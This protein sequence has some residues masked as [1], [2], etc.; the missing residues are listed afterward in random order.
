[1]PVKG[2]RLG[3]VALE[4]VHEHNPHHT[5]EQ[6]YSDFT[7][8]PTAKYLT[9]SPDT[10]RPPTAS[11]KVVA[12][13]PFAV[14]PTP[15]PQLLMLPAR[16]MAIDPALRPRVSTQQTD[17]YAWETDR[18]LAMPTTGQRATKREGKLSGQRL[19][20]Y[21]GRGLKSL[22]ILAFFIGGAIVDHLL[23]AQNTTYEMV[24]L[25]LLLIAVSNLYSGML[26]GHY[27][28][29]LQKLRTNPQLDALKIG[30]TSQF[31]VLKAETT[32]Y[33]RAINLTFSR[34]EG[35]HE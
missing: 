25:F 20:G 23:L 31:G 7:A 9:M 30:V 5:E 21:T 32:A 17:A 16:T 28:A 11:Q 24:V 27:N 12:I 4:R 19:R 26:K 1:M 22:L 6:L 35:Q 34:R 29:H 33:L 15:G 8:L 13:H 14:S 18:L 3:H 2:R 10:L